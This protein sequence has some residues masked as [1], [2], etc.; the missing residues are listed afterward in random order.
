MDSSTINNN[1][2]GSNVSVPV[3]RNAQ[4]IIMGYF[5]DPNIEYNVNDLYNLTHIN[6]KTI[7]S[8]VSELSK[9]GFLEKFYRPGEKVFTYRKGS[10]EYSPA[11]PYMDPRSSTITNIPIAR[12][13]V[14]FPKPISQIIMDLF[15]DPNTELTYKMTVDASGLTAN[16][17]SG[18]LWEFANKGYLTKFRKEGD[19]IFWYKK[20][21]KPFG[22]NNVEN[23]TDIAEEQPREDLFPNLE[24]S[25]NGEGPERSLPEETEMAEE[26]ANGV[27]PM[28]SNESYQAELEDISEGLKYPNWPNSEEQQTQ[29][30][31]QPITSIVKVKLIAT[32]GGKDFPMSIPEAKDLFKTL[33]QLFGNK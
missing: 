18:R 4:D 23:P 22:S 6:R 27:Q 15:S 10:M 7:S 16:Q 29:Q 31:Q 28:M 9:R 8:R 26:D 12:Q 17:V 3:K 1:N 13:N 20:G 32:V 19:S 25:L 2:T 5:S 33:E 14:N 21:N 24:K 30:E 11:T